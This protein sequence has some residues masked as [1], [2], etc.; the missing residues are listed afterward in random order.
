MNSR[1]RLIFSNK[2]NVVDSTQFQLKAVFFISF[3]I[4]NRNK[5]CHDSTCKKKRNLNL[6]KKRELLISIFHS[7]LFA[8]SLREDNK[9]N[10]KIQEI[11]LILM[12]ENKD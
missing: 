11:I 7:D 2:L 4:F 1:K 12:F 10:G 5:I 9:K 3:C 6:P 8:F